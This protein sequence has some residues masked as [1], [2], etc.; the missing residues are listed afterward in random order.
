MWVLGARGA[1][2]RAPSTPP[3][4]PGARL[5]W[6]GAPPVSPVELPGLPLK[7]GW[8]GCGSPPPRAKPEAAPPGDALLSLQGA[9]GQELGRGRC[10]RG[11]REASPAPLPVSLY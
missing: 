8:Q 2:G 1:D 6:R 10:L 7:G 4:A 9:G 5:R 3:V 11:S